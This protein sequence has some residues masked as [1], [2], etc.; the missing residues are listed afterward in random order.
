MWWVGNEAGIQARPRGV[1]LQHGYYLRRQV[2]VE[3]L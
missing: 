1:G 2:T 3:S